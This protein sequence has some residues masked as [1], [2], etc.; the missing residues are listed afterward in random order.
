MS[1]LCKAFILVIIA[2]IFILSGAL[3]MCFEA[4]DFLFPFA[5]ALIILGSA[6]GMIAASMFLYEAMR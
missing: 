6:G 5:V 2:V 1:N 4:T 3:L